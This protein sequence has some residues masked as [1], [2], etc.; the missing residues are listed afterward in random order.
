M[1]ICRNMKCYCQ[2][3]EW[4]TTAVLS[5]VAGIL[6]SSIWGV[7]HFHR[8]LV[9]WLQQDLLLHGFV[10]GSLGI[11]DVLLIF[12]LLCLGFSDCAKERDSYTYRGRRTARPPMAL[13]WVEWFGKNPLRNTHIS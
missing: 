9:L 8:E 2:Q 10:I 13:H 7:M 3:N 12:G 4:A 5:L 11:A 1:Q 6:F